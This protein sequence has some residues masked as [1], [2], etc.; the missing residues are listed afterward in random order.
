MKRKIEDI[1]A[2]YQAASEIASRDPSILPYNTRA[3]IQ[4]AMRAAKDKM[5]ELRKEYDDKLFSNAYAVIAE[6]DAAKVEQ[7]KVATTAIG[8]FVF[9]FDDLYEVIAC[10]VE[11][12]IGFNR[13]FGINQGFMMMQALREILESNG[14]EFQVKDPGVGVGVLVHTHQDVVNYIRESLLKAFGN[15][16][17]Y[18]YVRAN[19]LRRALTLGHAKKA[20]AVTFTGGDGEEES[21]VMPLFKNMSIVDVSDVEIDQTYAISVYNKLNK[22]P[23]KASSHNDTKENENE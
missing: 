18:M 2:D 12:S 8:G 6:G 17:V 10:A 23:N 7:F 14:V 1:L 11:P 21:A 19:L 3:G 16:V 22:K 20:L 4:N 13:T 9:N 15:T 5:V